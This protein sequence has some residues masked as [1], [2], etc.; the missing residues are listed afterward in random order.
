MTARLRE[1]SHREFI[2]I[3]TA[4]VGDFMIRS[5][6]TDLVAA[7]LLSLR[8]PGIPWSCGCS[9]VCK[10]I[11]LPCILRYD[12][13]GVLER[14]LHVLWELIWKLLTKRLSIGD[15][16]IPLRLFSRDSSRE[17]RFWI[18]FG[19][20]LPLNMWRLLPSWLTRSS[21]AIHSVNELENNQS[22][23]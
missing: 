17:Q 3:A 22:N 14:R 12:I 7:W 1:E 19:V 15:G 9:F 21:R 5:S 6:T 23:K 10:H 8:H 4:R 18:S 16:I 20:F 2:F 11:P 13:S